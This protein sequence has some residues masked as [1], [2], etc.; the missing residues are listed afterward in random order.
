MPDKMVNGG[1]IGERGD[2][3]AAFLHERL[4]RLAHRREA[5]AGQHPAEVFRPRRDAAHRSKELQQL[6]SGLRHGLCR[7][8]MYTFSNHLTPPINRSPHFDYGLQAQRLK[9]KVSQRESAKVAKARR[10]TEIL[11]RKAGK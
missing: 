3:N 2:L 6:R 11:I 4:Q 9:G 10:G 7:L 1:A 5:A 8:L